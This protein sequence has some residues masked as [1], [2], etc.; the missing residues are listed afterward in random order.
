M[1]VRKVFRTGDSVVVPLPPEALEPLGVAV[2][3]DVSVEVDAERKVIVIRPLR[4]ALPDVDEEFARQVSEFI[5]E[6]RPALEALARR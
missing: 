4:P 6:Y 5:E 1:V 2:G 3:Q